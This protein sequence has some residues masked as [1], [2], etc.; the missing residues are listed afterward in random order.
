MIINIYRVIPLNFAEF[1]NEG[2]KAKVR[3]K[4]KNSCRFTMTNN[5]RKHSFNETFMN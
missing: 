3:A 2:R 4:V 1:N 5:T